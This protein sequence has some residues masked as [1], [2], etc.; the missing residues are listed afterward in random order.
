MLNPW[1]MALRK[2]DLYTN[3]YELEDGGNCEPFY[4]RFENVL[5]GWACTFDV[6]V[7]NDIDICN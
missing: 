3:F 5:A 1:L 7:K 2:G 4:E 6:A